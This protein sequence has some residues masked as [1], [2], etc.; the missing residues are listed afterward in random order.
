MAEKSD[1]ELERRTVLQTA[2]VVGTG[3]ITGT[4]LT[5]AST[6]SAAEN[7]STE[8]GLEWRPAESEKSETII[9]SDFGGSDP[10]DIDDPEDDLR[11]PKGIVA[12]W[13]YHDYRVVTELT[14]KYFN[15]SMVEGGQ[16]G[17]PEFLHHFGLFAATEVQVRWYDNR[18]PTWL[19]DWEWVP[20]VEGPIPP[21]GWH[22]WPV[23]SRGVTGNTNLEDFKVS[24]EVLNDDDSYVLEKPTYHDVGFGPTSAPIEEPEDVSEVRFNTLEFA[25]DLAWEAAGVIPI[26]GQTLA[27][28][29]ILY[30]LGD[31]TNVVDDQPDPFGIGEG[32][33]EEV[34][35][36]MQELNYYSDGYPDNMFTEGFFAYGFDIGTDCHCPEIN[37]G[38]DV[39]VDAPENPNEGT[40]S[41]D[42]NKEFDDAVYVSDNVL[43][44]GFDGCEL[45]KVDVEVGGDNCG[46]YKFTAKPQINFE[47]L[48]SSSPIEYYWRYS[49]TDEGITLS[50]DMQV[51][52]EEEHW[53]KPNPATLSYADNLYLTEGEWAAEFIVEVEEDGET[54]TLID[55]DSVNFESYGVVPPVAG[56]DPPQDLDND[57]LYEDVNGDGEF[58]IFDVQFLFENLDNE[59]VEEY[60]QYYD[61]SGM[62]DNRASIFDV[63]HLF[64]QL[65]EQTSTV[66]NRDRLRPSP[67]PNA[68]AVF[69]TPRTVDTHPGDTITYEIAIR[70]SG[71]T[72][73]GGV[74]AYALEVVIEDA[75]VARF[76]DFEENASG[77]SMSR[78]EIRFSKTGET[79][80]S[81]D[82]LWLETA[83]ADDPYLP[84]SNIYIAEAEIELT[85]DI[86]QGS[87]VTISS[88]PITD[89]YGPQVSPVMSWLDPYPTKMLGKS[90]IDILA[91][92]VTGDGNR[93]AD[94]TGDGLLND[95]NGDGKFNVGDVQALNDNLNSDAVQSNPELFNFNEEHNPEEVT[96]LDVQ[97][98]FNMIN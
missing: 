40:P 92:D 84:D 33:K 48:T 98:L 83:L 87:D 41:I 71:D 32:Q 8:S 80:D 85:G 45:A 63:Q 16:T 93:A 86:G 81:G 96:M 3:L 49:H 66:Q 95:V 57:L 24:V 90:T 21:N 50:T 74:S 67:E 30:S 7:D 70:S 43:D 12:P 29:S 1:K 17:E 75:D 62:D 18:G 31:N 56:G 9:K 14:I 53:S 58:D 69:A 36:V 26:S 61:F 35:D 91:P 20:W 25:E 88:E 13:L 38:F 78:S 15:S 11:K 76:V 47:E 64:N 39:D 94:T 77:N 52:T 51:Y 19:T 72:V 65:P 46:E 23:E 27:G 54:V 79:A 60:S 6:A 42:T 2:P 4:G 68:I 82:V 10:S 34:F 97:A 55:T 5:N 89:D 28:A 22:E 37:L 59:C 73:S 44:C